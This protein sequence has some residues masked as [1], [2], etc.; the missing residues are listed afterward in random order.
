MSRSQL[1]FIGASSLAAA[2]LPPGPSHPLPRAAGGCGATRDGEHLA[3]ALILQG[4][5]PGKDPTL[6]ASTP[7]V[8]T[9][10]QQQPRSGAM[11]A[12]ALVFSTRLPSPACGCSPELPPCLRWE[13]ETVPWCG[14][15]ALCSLPALPVPNCGRGRQEL[16]A[17]LRQQLPG[18]KIPATS[19]HQPWAV[20]KM[21]LECV[22]TLAGAGKTAVPV[23]DAAVP[24]A[25]TRCSACCCPVALPSCP[26]PSPGVP[27]PGSSSRAWGW[28]SRRRNPLPPSLS[29]KMKSRWDTRSHPPP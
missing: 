14:L 29:P 24:A 15:P 23:E 26:W 13:S 19:P 27:C 2:E 18:G 10:P 12:A 4:G 6:V 21:H 8:P 1:S 28:A 5:V 17:V 9:G 25:R 3:T 20:S 16:Q 11:Q 22:E 7:P